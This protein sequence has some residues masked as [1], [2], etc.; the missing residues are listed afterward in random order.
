MVG[1]FSYHFVVLVPIYNLVASVL[2]FQHCFWPLHSHSP[3]PC[4]CPLLLPPLGSGRALAVCSLTTC[5]ISTPL[6]A[7][8]MFRMTS[9][10]LF[11]HLPPPALWLQALGSQTLLYPMAVDSPL[12]T[13][14]SL[15][16]SLLKG[17][18]VHSTRVLGECLWL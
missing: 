4:P 10:N 16:L 13:T 1:L 8:S 17:S 6:P 5:S 7:L 9:L 3:R 15:S 11:L 12:P 14:M 2:Q 18:S